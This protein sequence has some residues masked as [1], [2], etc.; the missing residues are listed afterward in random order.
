MIEDLYIFK[1]FFVRLVLRIKMCNR[2]D[3]REL[4]Q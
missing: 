2:L 4:K 3:L 1:P